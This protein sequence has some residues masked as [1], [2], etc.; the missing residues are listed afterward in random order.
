MD[1]PVIIKI[2]T[3]FSMIL[4]RL[5]CPSEDEEKDFE[6]ALSEA[7]NLSQNNEQKNCERKIFGLK[8][9]FKE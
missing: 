9:D 5:I 8:G 1:F 4:D 2:I 3:S 6:D 7:D